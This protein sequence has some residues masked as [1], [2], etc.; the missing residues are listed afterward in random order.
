M[1]ITDED[2][3]SGLKKI[4]GTFRDAIILADVE[5][6]SY[7]EIASIYNIPIGTVMSRIHRGRKLLRIELS[8]YARKCG[9]RSAAAAG[10]Q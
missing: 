6:F 10:D 2:V 1:G 8:D 4:P 9:L 7:S 3:L 5:G